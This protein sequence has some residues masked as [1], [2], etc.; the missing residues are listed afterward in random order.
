MQKEKPKMT[1]GL[2]ES[3]NFQFPV[4][5]YIK[6]NW[7]YPGSRRI[8]NPASFSYAGKKKTLPKKERRALPLFCYRR[9]LPDKVIND[10]DFLKLLPVNL[11]HLTHQ[12]PADKAVQDT[13]VQ[14]LYRGILPDFPDKGADIAFLLIGTAQGEGQFF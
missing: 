6:K 5:M 10:F 4:K 14:F 8:A 13:L 3:D 7:S 11:F 1:I 12:N 2:L 9:D